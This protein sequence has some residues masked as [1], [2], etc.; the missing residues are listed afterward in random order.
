MA[1]IQDLT[2][3]KLHI[4]SNFVKMRFPT[5]MDKPFLYP[6]NIWF[7]VVYLFLMKMLNR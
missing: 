2:D 1:L 3:D 5:E 6:I 7:V 4:L